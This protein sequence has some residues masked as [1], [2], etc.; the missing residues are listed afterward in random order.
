MMVK[1]GLGLAFIEKEAARI[2]G[3]GFTVLNYFAD[4]KIDSSK[5]IE[6]STPS[7][8]SLR[9]FADLLAAVRN[10]FTTQVTTLWN[11][12]VNIKNRA[13]GRMNFENGSERLDSIKQLLMSVFKQDTTLVW[14]AKR[15]FVWTFAW[16]G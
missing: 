7:T 8:M 3:E 16:A 15:K 1:A 13:V 12:I 10:C 4:F 2:Q 11:L 9:T 6:L 14:M 5:K